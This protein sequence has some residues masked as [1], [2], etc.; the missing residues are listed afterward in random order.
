MSARL[1]PAA[2]L[3][4]NSKLFALPPAIALPVAPPSSSEIQHSDTATTPFPRFA[5]IETTETCGK[6]GDWGFKRALPSKSFKNTN[7]PVVR[8]VRGIDTAEHVADFE[9]AA[10]HTLT[11]RKFSELDHPLKLAETD[12][13]SKGIA[14]DLRNGVFRA[15]SDNTTNLTST[16]PYKAGYSGLYGEASA[17]AVRAELPPKLRK[18]EDGQTQQDLG[19]SDRKRGMLSSRIPLKRWRYTGPSLAAISGEQFEEYLKGLGQEEKTRLFDQIR[20]QVVLDKQTK[21]RD[22]G[23]LNEEFKKEDVTE[24]ELQDHIR[25][26]RETPSVFGPMIAKVLDLPF[27]Q[28]PDRHRDNPNWWDYGRS[29]LASPIWGTEGTPATHPSAGLSYTAGTHSVNH[30]KYGPQAVNHPVVTRAVRKQARVVNQSTT[31]G[32]AGFIMTGADGSRAQ[33]GAKPFV[34]ADGG[35][36][37]AVVPA[38]AYIH[39]NGSL[40]MRVEETSNFDVLDDKAVTK[41]E[42]SEALYRAQLNAEAGRESDM[43]RETQPAPSFS[44]SDSSNRSSI[45][46]RRLQRNTSRPEP[47]DLDEI[48]KGKR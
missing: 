29:T 31:Y 40:R 11:L 32:V 33:F 19:T 6:V 14:R 17:S 46:D 2:S 8:L 42:L 4:R 37:A 10:D 48:L 22:Q 28:P 16:S 5:A 21:S 20:D 7:N 24:Q 23:V 12:T 9:S 41:T 39:A 3:L 13:I 45:T 25:Y 47:V 38:Q 18:Q 34:K 36:K 27:V 43:S 1:S 15:S 44:N 35:M 30:P 26:L